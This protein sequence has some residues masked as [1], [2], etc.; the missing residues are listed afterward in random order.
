MADETV[1]ELRAKFKEQIRGLLQQANPIDTVPQNAA[2][3]RCIE[4]WTLTQAKAIAEGQSNEQAKILA[5]HTYRLAIPPLVGAQNISDFI[6]C[7]AFGALLG[8][9]SSD[10]C[11]RLLYAA[12]V[13]TGAQ[14]TNPNFR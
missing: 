6:A 1:E 14:K 9:I 10:E 8:S 2:V 5:D 3:N 12:Q 11:S 13:A 7:V 4:C